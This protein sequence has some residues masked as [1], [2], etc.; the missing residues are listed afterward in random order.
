MQLY[1]PTKIYS[2]ENCVNSHAKE[3]TSYGKKAMIVTGKNSAKKCGALA[4]VEQALQQAQLAYV[5]FDKIEENPSVETVMKATEVGIHE[6]VDFV[7]GIGGGSPLD[8]AKAIAL[9]IANPQEAKEVLYESKQLQA[10]PVVCIPTTCGTG[11]EVTPYAILT[12]HE[13]KTKKSIS[14]RIY[15]AMALLD[16]KY[17]QSMSYEGLVNTAVDALAHL[18]ESYL[19]TNA[20]EWNRIYSMEGMRIWGT[21]KYRL[22]ENQLVQEDYVKMLHASMIAGM[23]IAHTGTSLPH[24]LSYPVTYELGVP[25]G[26]AVGMF[27]GGF[28]AGYQNQEEVKTILEVLGFETVESFCRYM[29]SVSG[30]VSVPEEL[31]RRNAKSLLENPAKLKNYPFAITE[32]EL[33]QMVER[34]VKEDG[35]TVVAS[36]MVYGSLRNDAANVQQRNGEES[37]ANAYDDMISAE[38]SHI[39]W[40]DRAVFYHIYP[41]GLCGCPHD[42]H[43]EEGHYFEKLTAWARHANDM[44]VTAIYIGPLFESGSHGYDTTDYRKVDSRLGTNEE[45]AHFVKDCH[46]MGMKVIVDGVFNHVGREFFAFKDL[47]EHREQARYKDWFCDLNFGGNNEY[48]DN[49]S[50]GNWGGFNLLVK[51]NL[52]NPE[53]KNYHFDTVRYWIDMFDI[54]GIRLDAA[55]VLDM[56]FMRELRYVADGLKDDFWL[57]GEVIHGDYSRWANMDTLYSVT[58]YELHKGLFSG[59]NDHNY[60]EIAHSVKRLLGICG[61]TKLYLFSDNHDV[62]RLA[63]K[64]NNRKHIPLVATLVYTLPGIPS[65]Y[66][67]SEY[68]IEGVKDGT[69]WPLRPCLEIEQFE[70]DAEAQKLQR[71]YKRLGALK[72]KYAQL[73]RGTYQELFLTNRQYAFARVSEGQALVVCYNNDDNVARL[74]IN[75]P[76]QA[77]EAE[78][79][80]GDKATVRIENGRLV[81]NLDANEQAIILVK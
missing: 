45:F 19:N 73:T 59:H 20:N 14:H 81:V 29:T 70:N 40:Y 51:L 69:D 36:E 32:Q 52:W 77:N 80:L 31:M 10:L 53:V 49:F 8:A 24:G 66:Y 38:V 54:D 12:I 57:M 79:L 30:N 22:K 26:K 21:F 65:I 76:I 23:A 78:L 60:F 63:S 4:D 9:M 1:L 11:S 55:D 75:P 42:N 56:N 18:I 15:P 41:L 34:V 74:E 3:L 5:I 62:L 47:K 16:A 71:H 44:N 39:P 50:Y 67:G 28:V 43:G 64:I 7:I 58:N 13:Q 17:L 68:G 48:N 6:Q 25:H 27:L 61:D 35:R 72:K 2:E 33:M 46:A 37:V